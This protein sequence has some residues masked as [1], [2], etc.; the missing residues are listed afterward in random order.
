MRKT[1]LL[2]TLLLLSYSLNAQVSVSGDYSIRVDNNNNDPGVD[3]FKIY[4]GKG[5]SPFFR[6]S[7]Q[8]VKFLSDEILHYA[9]DRFYL[10]SEKDV[11]M[12][13]GRHNNTS[14]IFK[15]QIGHDSKNEVFRTSLAESTFHTNSFKLFGYKG[16]DSFLDINRG[17]FKAKH[18]ASFSVHIDDNSNDPNVDTFKIL[19]GTN[20]AKIFDV[21]ISNTK[22]FSRN[23]TSENDGSFLVNID[24]NNNSQVDKF[25]VL[26]G[27]EKSEVLTAGGNNVVV[28]KELITQNIKAQDILANK[29]VLN[30]GSFPDY[31]FS[32]TYELMP[33]EKV[34]EYIQKNKHLPSMPSELEVIE[35]G[36]D[37]KNLT[38]KLVE[39]VEELTLYTIQQQETINKLKQ[40]IKN[41]KQ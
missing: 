8:Y 14:A 38:L 2:L 18:S 7:N 28:H 22:L 35:E 41:D 36:M 33:L 23:F 15:V 5:S 12:R 21:G 13:V 9:K 3:Y 37:L 26:Y 1:I 19:H 30:V 40:L 32:D 4:Q 24:K 25:K 10:M 20:G 39:K 27:R 16:S 6:G 11:E 17:S 34:K 31:V 29:V